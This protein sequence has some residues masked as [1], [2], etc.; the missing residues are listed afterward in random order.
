MFCSSCGAENAYGLR[1]CKRCGENLN[2]PATA[3]EINVKKVKQ[4]E[5]G[6]EIEEIETPGISIKK[7]SGLFWAVAVFGF[8][9]L[10]GLFGTLIPLMLL[11]ADKKTIVL[12]LI[13]GSG[14]IGGIAAML[15]Q[16]L[17]RLIAIVENN[18][19]ARHRV[20]SP[21]EQNRP[22]MDAPPKSVSSVTE[23]TTR[24]FE[25]PVYD[26]RSARE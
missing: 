21:V 15:I 16:Q 7:L 3:P 9:S 8:I 1:Y 5:Y 2:N 10:L 14:A 22:Q 24:N 17:A 18:E 13:F 11:H 26:N 12:V 25:Q 19:R 20:R 23:H 4:G 6:W